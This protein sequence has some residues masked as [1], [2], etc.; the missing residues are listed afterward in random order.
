MIYLMLIAAII[1]AIF[2]S[3]HIEKI[4]REDQIKR[5]IENDE[6]IRDDK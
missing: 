1:F 2:I 3:N 6:V 4:K 5:E